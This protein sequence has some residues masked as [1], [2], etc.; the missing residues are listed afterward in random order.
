M[1]AAENYIYFFSSFYLGV[2]VFAAIILLIGTM[3]LKNEFKTESYNLL[4]VFNTLVAWCSPLGLGFYLIELFLAWYG[5][6]PYEW[7]AFYTGSPSTNVSWPWLLIKICL[8]LFLGLLFF[9]RRLRVNRL[10]TLCFLILLNTGLIEQLIYRFT[11]DYLPSSWSAYY[12][13]PYSEKIIKYSA[14][15]FFLTII[16]FIAKKKNKLPYP[17]LFLK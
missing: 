5:Q 4:Y 12:Y 9:F 13:E 17:S 11:R 10:Y 8:P 16:Y 2:Y 7:Y 15:F 3:F 6:N 1:D 14:I